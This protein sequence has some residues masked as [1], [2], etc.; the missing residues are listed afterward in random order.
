[1]NPP[2]AGGAACPSAGC[3]NCVNNRCQPACT[4]QNDCVDGTVCLMG[5]CTLPNNTDSQVGQPCNA[6]CEHC[7]TA[8]DTE[9]FAQSICTLACTTD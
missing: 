9:G 1:M 6:D 3:T 5:A 8:L 4:T 2:A 7:T